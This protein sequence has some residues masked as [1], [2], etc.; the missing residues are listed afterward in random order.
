VPAEEFEAAATLPTTLRV[1]T[2]EAVTPFPNYL[3]TAV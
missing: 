1:A 2:P 3:R